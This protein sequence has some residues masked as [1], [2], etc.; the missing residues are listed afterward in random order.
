MNHVRQDGEQQARTVTGTF[1]QSSMTSSSAN[2][3]TQS[4]PI[5]T[6]TSA[7]FMT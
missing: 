3:Q 4:K 7:T 2:I 5:M 6:Q 1:Y